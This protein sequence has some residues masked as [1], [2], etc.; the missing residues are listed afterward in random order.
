MR[1]FEE[2]NTWQTKLDSVN[3]LK[4]CR[5]KKRLKSKTLL[6]VFCCWWTHTASPAVSGHIWSRNTV[7]SMSIQLLLN[8]YDDKLMGSSGVL[9]VCV[10]QEKSPLVKRV[11]NEASCSLPVTRLRSSGAICQLPSTSPCETS[12]ELYFLSILIRN[13]CDLLS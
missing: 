2:N 13:S 6:Q 8:D 4:M 12:R 11:G 9:F 7:S 10:S 1:G 5:E 3:W